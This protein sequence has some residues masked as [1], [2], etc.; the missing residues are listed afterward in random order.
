MCLIDLGVDFFMEFSE[1]IIYEGCESS[2]FK[3]GH[4]SDEVHESLNPLGKS[5][6]A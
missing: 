1:V 4:G 2:F 6:V 5:N 3:Q